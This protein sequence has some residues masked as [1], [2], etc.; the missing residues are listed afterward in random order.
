LLLLG[1]VLLVALLA[2]RSCAA[3]HNAISQDEAVAIAKK[4]VD[5]TPC[6]KPRCVQIRYLNQGIPVRGFWL[7]GLAETLDE[8]GNPLRVQSVLIDAKTGAVSPR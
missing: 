6:S 5:F 4:N 2:S 3:R 8:N 1:L 7:V